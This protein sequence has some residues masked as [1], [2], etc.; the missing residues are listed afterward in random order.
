MLRSSFC[1]ENEKKDLIKEFQKKDTRIKEKIVNMESE[2]TGDSEYEKKVHNS[3]S[4]KF[5]GEKTKEKQLC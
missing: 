1:L 5:Y 3:G 2:T 4:S